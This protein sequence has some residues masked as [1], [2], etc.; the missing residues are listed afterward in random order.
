MACLVMFTLLV[1]SKQCI[2]S[3]SLSILHIYYSG[4]G[5]VCNHEKIHLTQ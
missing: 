1:I 3:I 2:R 5:F 4:M